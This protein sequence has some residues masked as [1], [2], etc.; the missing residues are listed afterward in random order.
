MFLGCSSHCR[1]ISWCCRRSPS[2]EVTAKTTWMWPETATRC[3][4]TATGAK[5]PPKRPHTSHPALQLSAE[6]S[7]E[8]L[9]VLG[10]WEEDLIP[11][12]LFPH[13]TSF[14][15]EVAVTWTVLELLE[16]VQKRPWRCSVCYEHRLR[17]LHLFSLEKKRILGD[18]TVALQ[19]IWEAS[20]KD[21]KTFS[22]EG[23][24][25]LIGG[26]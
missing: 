12:I 5:V 8:N 13:S 24:M 6:Q 19:C 4:K 18:L 10:P 1:G 11:F 2:P 16:R 14:K 9:L 22:G 25:V 3:T 21:W 7:L 15:Q 26:W 20:K 23:A 17:E